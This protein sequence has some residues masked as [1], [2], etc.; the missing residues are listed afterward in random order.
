MIDLIDNLIELGENENDW[1]HEVPRKID[2]LVE[3]GVQFTTL[4]IGCKM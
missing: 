4:F 1:V 3:Q 2:C